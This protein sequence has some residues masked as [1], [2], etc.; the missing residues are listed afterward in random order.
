MAVAGNAL[1]MVETSA[2]DDGI[3]QVRRGPED[4]RPCCDLGE[5]GEREIALAAGSL[6]NARQIPAKA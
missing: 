4:G 6:P 1:L 3:R 5:R 2:I